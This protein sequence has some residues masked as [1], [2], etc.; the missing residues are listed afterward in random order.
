MARRFV[1][2][3]AEQLWGY[4]VQ[5]TGVMYQ[6]FWELK[7]DLN[8]SLLSAIQRRIHSFFVHVIRCNGSVKLCI[9]GKVMVKEIEVGRRLDP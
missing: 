3:A 7:I 4:F 5:Y 8:E 6:F 2:P 1:S 9:Q